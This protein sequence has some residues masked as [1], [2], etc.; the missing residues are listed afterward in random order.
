MRGRIAVTGAGGFI[1]RHLVTTLAAHGMVVAAISRRE[2]TS[3]AGVT[4]LPAPELDRQTDWGPLLDGCDALVHLAGVAHRRVIDPSAYAAELQRVNVE[5]TAG[6][7]I[8]ARRAGVRRLVF[9][10]SLAA[11][12]SRSVGRVDA[13]TP[14]RPTGP[15]G[16]SKLAAEKAL[17][18]LGRDGG[19]AVTVLRPPVVYGAGNRANMDHL[20]RLVRSG[21]PL[22][23]G[24]LRNRRSL[25]YVG[26]LCDVVH[27]CLVT[28]APVTGTYLVSDG[29]DLSTPELIRLIA[30]ATGRRARLLPFPSSAWHLAARLQPDG[31]V[32]KLVGSLYLDII[33]L[34]RALE[35]T[36]PFTAEEGLRMA[37]AGREGAS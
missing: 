10:S 7:Y 28:P 24:G 37:L 9:M 11:V 21:L 17:V 33:P 5:T 4:W 35:W 29:R 23:F 16:R 22:P 1:G 3:A 34:A 19:P 25:I 13:S 27:R 32:A 14:P 36:A 26:N 30:G 15:Y 8:A 20:F 18:D 2:P 31:P 6:L 12:T